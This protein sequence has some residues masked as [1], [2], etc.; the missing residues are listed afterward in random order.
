MFCLV[1][2][3]T[4][5]AS[6]LLLAQAI[7]PKAFY[8]WM[9]AESDTVDYRWYE[10]KQIYKMNLIAEAT[11]QQYRQD[12][13]SPYAFAY[14]I[15]AARWLNSSTT[16]VKLIDSIA[17]RISQYELGTHNKDGFFYNS[18]AFCFNGCYLLYLGANELESA[19]KMLARN[20]ES[21][22]KAQELSSPGNDI[23]NSSLFK[24][25]GL[26]SNKGMLLYQATHHLDSESKR[27]EAGPMIISYLDRADSLGEVY[28]KHASLTS[29]EKAVR[30]ITLSTNKYL[31]YG[32]YFFNNKKADESLAR[33]KS[34]KDQY[35]KDSENISCLNTQTHMFSS[36]SW[37]RFSKK[38]YKAAIKE[39][40]KFHDYLVAL[41]KTEAL[42]GPSTSSHKSYLLYVLTDSYYKCAKPDSAYYFGELYLADTLNS[43]DFGCM[44]EIASLMAE[45]SLDK[46]IK[47]AKELL[48]VSK[49]CIK[50]SQAEQVRTQI[51]RE[52][53]IVQLNNSLE[54]VLTISEKVRLIEELESDRILIIIMLLLV[55]SII[56]T[57]VFFVKLRKT[58]FSLYQTPR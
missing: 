57:V 8:E 13:Y 33:A 22:I 36:M 53:E 56:T 2:V 7:Q 18:L 41:E 21:L 50:R 5:Q 14:T 3:L 6:N 45:L 4:G 55:A 54:K 1:L 25:I 58:R 19:K 20:E 23:Y 49:N 10:E 32:G 28:L 40:R 15:H 42:R 9:S 27:N 52:G 24:L 48:Q 16:D 35:C 17:N 47:R 31:V 46:D 26:Y 29:P 30:M 37:V 51:I 38:D 43:K 11:L 34:L 12:P 44:S 39:G